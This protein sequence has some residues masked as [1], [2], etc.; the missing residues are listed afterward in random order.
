MLTEEY[1]RAGSFI[2]RDPALLIG[3]LHEPQVNEH[4]IKQNNRWKR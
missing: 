3:I 2:S 1:E 4:N